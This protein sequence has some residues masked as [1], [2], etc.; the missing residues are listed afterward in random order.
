MIKIIETNISIYADENEYLRIINDFQS[1]VIEVYSWEDYVQEIEES[2]SV[3]RNSVI[4]NLH[5]VT[6]P[7]DSVVENLT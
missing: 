6:I 7:E 5:G 3:Y 2:E 4:G 1:R